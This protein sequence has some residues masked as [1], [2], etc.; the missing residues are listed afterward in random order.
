MDVFWGILAVL[1]ST[2]DICGSNKYRYLIVQ[3]IDKIRILRVTVS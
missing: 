3:V 1:A 2:P